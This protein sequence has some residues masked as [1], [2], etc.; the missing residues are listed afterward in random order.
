MDLFLPRRHHPVV[1]CPARWKRGPA[2]IRPARQVHLWN[3][4]GILRVLVPLALVLTLAYLPARGAPA[5]DT[6]AAEVTADATD[7]DCAR[8]WFD[9]NLRI[10]EIQTVGTAESYK[11]RPSDA[12]LALIKMGSADDAKALDFAQAPIAEQLKM[13][14]RSL[15]FDIAY[16]PK[17]GLYKIPPGPSLPAS[18]WPP[19]AI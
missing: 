14:A 19:P 4:G 8:A 1:A 7:A 17:G 15:A 16:D 10:N 11:L 6:N 5:C 9:A 3:F 12:M 2:P 18:P 13:G